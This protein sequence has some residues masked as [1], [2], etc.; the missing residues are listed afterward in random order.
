VPEDKVAEGGYS[1]E[2]PPPPP[3]LSPRLTHW[4]N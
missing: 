4:R 2:A 3:P 1:D